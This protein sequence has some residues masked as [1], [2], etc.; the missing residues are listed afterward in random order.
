MRSSR[1]ARFALLALAVTAGTALAS[2]M[3][4]AVELPEPGE[5]RVDPADELARR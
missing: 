3:N 1:S 2:E 4:V 5:A